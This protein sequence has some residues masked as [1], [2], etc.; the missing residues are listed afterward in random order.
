MTSDRSDWSGLP[1]ADRPVTDEEIQRELA[2]L[3][4]GI[5][6]PKSRF[7]DLRKAILDPALFELG[8]GKQG[9]GFVRQSGGFTAAMEIAR[10]KGGRAFR[11][12][13]GLQPA[14][15]GKSPAFEE[16]PATS[17]PFRGHVGYPGGLCW[18]KH[19]LD[20]A[21]TRHVLTIAADFLKAELDDRLLQMMEFCETATPANVA[22]PP[23]WLDPLMVDEVVFARYR[24]ASGR[25]AEAQDFARAAL[26]KLPPA[27]PLAHLDPPR[28]LE[29]ELRSIAEG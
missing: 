22:H 29:V 23:V 10:D 7:A 3:A 19:G 28:P 27:G 15:M 18:W 4:K 16:C 1:L 13:L 6:P 11:I 24:K 21:A 2:D 5:V 25:D 8:F 20:E 17:A 26:A 12:D 14:A 9:N